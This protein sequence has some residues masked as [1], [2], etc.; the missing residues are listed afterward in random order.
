LEQSLIAE[1]I[2]TVVLIC[3]KQKKFSGLVP[4]KQQNRGAVPPTSIN[5]SFSGI[6]TNARID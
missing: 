2:S 1:Q 3:K 5:P 6:A 4:H